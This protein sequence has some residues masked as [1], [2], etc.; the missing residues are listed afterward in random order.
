MGFHGLLQGYLYFLYLKEVNVNFCN[1][2]N[3]Y[4]EELLPHAQPPSWKRLEETA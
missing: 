4:G 2:L 1:K 3:F